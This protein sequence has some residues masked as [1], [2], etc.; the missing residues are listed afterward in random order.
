[1]ESSNDYLGRIIRA[2][3]VATNAM[4]VITAF[5]GKHNSVTYQ[6]DPFCQ[7]YPSS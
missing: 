4:A 2:K 3:A 5:K 7:G 1:M 6:Y